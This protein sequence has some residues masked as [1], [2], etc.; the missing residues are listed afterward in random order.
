VAVGVWVG[1]LVWLLAVVADRD[2]PDRA[3]AARRFSTVGGVAVAVVALTG[4]LREL[5]EAGG[6]AA[7]AQSLHTAFGRA[8]ALK[9]GLFGGLLA[10]AA[11]NRF[12]T[13]PML[14][15]PRRGLRLLRRVVTAE[16]VVAAAILGVTAV[17]SQLPP[18]SQLVALAERATPSPAPRPV[19]HIQR[20]A[21][22]ITLSAFIDPG[23]EG[24]NRVQFD[25]A[26][27]SG[28]PP[29]I[30]SVTGT[31]VTPASDVFRM[32]LTVAGPGRFV[33]HVVLEHGPG[34]WVFKITARTADGTVLRG[35]FEQA[36]SP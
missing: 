27:A 16:V 36:V 1:G 10:L 30:V 6:P 9:V 33:A 25:F 24:E 8:L 29:N 13:V 17:L 4:L 34:P 19:V 14:S 3:G 22:D 32:P 35:S 18:A 31:L 12:V 20:L 15:T 7:W 23:D 2:A 28:R 26:D 5:D 11:T 21:G